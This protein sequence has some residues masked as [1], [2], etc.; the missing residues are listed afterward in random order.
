MRSA[1][2]MCSRVGMRSCRSGSVRKR[3]KRNVMR[4]NRTNGREGLGQEPEQEQEQR[5]GQEQEQQGVGWGGIW[6]R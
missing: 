3:G 4:S 1:K 2:D 5:L 6:G